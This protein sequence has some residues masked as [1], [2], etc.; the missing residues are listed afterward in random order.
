MSPDSSNVSHT[1]ATCCGE[2]WREAAPRIP[3]GA[4]PVVVGFV[5][6]VIEMEVGGV[7]GV[8]VDV[9]FVVV[10]GAAVGTVGTDGADGVDVVVV[11]VGLEL[12]L[13]D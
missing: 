9:V 10:V 3:P 4:C 5:F 8:G 1:W 12:A 6:V 11:V 2:N 7:C 13:L